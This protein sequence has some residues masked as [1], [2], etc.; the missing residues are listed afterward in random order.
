MDIKIFVV[1]IP[2]LILLFVTERILAELRKKKKKKPNMQTSVPSQDGITFIL[3]L[4]LVTFI[5][6]HIPYFVSSGINWIL[7]QNSPTECGSI[8]YYIEW[9]DDV[10]LLLNSSAKD[11][12]ISSWTKTSGLHLCCTVAVRKVM[13]L[14]QLNWRSLP[15]GYLEV[16]EMCPEILFDWLVGWFVLFNDT[17]SQ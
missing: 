13:Q 14:S 12:S 10:G 9:L 2:F 7:N 11:L 5:I 6:C 16:G 4:I 8:M 17:W 15:V 3:V 1:G